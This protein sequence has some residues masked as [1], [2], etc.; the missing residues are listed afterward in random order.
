M[1][2]RA[3]GLRQPAPRH[4][5]HRK[6]RPRRTRVQR[7]VRDLGGIGAGR[8]FSLSIMARWSADKPVDDGSQFGFIAIVGRIIHASTTQ[9][10][11]WARTITWRYSS[12]ER[13]ML[14]ASAA[15]FFMAG[16]NRMPSTALIFAKPAWPRTKPV[17]Q[18]GAFALVCLESITY[19]PVCHAIR[20]RVAH[21]GCVGKGPGSCRQLT[22]FPQSRNCHT[23]QNAR[24]RP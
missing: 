21:P 8:S 17:F 4:H 12:G 10:L 3:A 16:L 6:R 2:R 13:P 14:L 23:G 20:M 22:Q 7:R 24:R 15:R 5:R 1:V 9:S 18:S 19:F 11:R